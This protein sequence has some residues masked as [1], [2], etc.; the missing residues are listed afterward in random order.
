MSTQATF[1]AL[2]N[3]SQ[4]PLMVGANVPP[5]VMLTIS[6]DQQLY[7]KAYNDY[8]D[9][10][11]DMPG[12]DKAIETSYKH[13]INY[14]GYF[15]SAKCYNY[16]VANRRFDPAA[17]VDPTTRYCSGQWSGNFLNWL[18]MSR[19]DAI[20][21]LLYGGMRSTD[22]VTPAG[23][24]AATAAA[25]VTVLERAYLPSDAH[26]WAKHYSGADLNKLTPFNVPTT[27]TTYA[28]T[29]LAFNIPNLNG[30]YLMTFAAS[31]TAN[32]SVG[33]QV[34]VQRAGNSAQ[35]FIGAVVSITSGNLVTF[36]INTAGVQ[37]SG[38][39]TSWNVTNLSRTGVSFCNMTPG[40]GGAD[41]RSSTNSQP[42]LIRVARGNFALWNASEGIQ[43]QWFEDRNNNQA[44]FP[45]GF[46]SNGNQLALSEI[47]ASAE[48]PSRAAHGLGTGSAVGEYIARVRVCVA[49]MLGDEKCARYP[50]GNFK[51]VG[52]LQEYGDRDLIHFGLMTGSHIK[53]IS[54]GVLR[55]NVGTI[56][57]EIN[58]NTD[59]TFVRPY[60]PAGSPRNTGS[61][62]EPAGI[63]NTL[64][65]MRIYGYDYSSAT[66]IGGNGD[67][68]TYQ[69]TSISENTCTSW[70]NPMSEVY[71]ESVRYFAGGTPTPAY[72]YSGASRDN[73]LG[74]PIVAAA[75]WNPGLA[76]HTYCAS[77]NII[78]FNA[79][80]STNDTDL[81]SAAASQIGGPAATTIGALTNRVGDAEGI[82]NGR[83]FIGKMLGGTPTPA[84]DAGFELCTPKTVTALGDVSG[85]CPEGPTTAGSYLIAGVAHYAKTNRIRS[86]IAVPAGN[87]QALKVSTYGI[88]L[89]TNTPSI[90]I[91]VPGSAGQNIVIQPIYRL[92]LPDGTVGGGSLV[93]MKFVR[94]STVGQISTGKI[95]VNWEDSE[96]GGD[97]DQ[98]MWGTLE[99]TLDAATRT[100]KITTNAISASSANGQGFGYAISGT[101]A[102]TDGPHFHS[103]IYGFNF[104]DPTGVLGCTNCRL[105]TEGV[106]GSQTGEQSV[107]YNGI[108]GI[109]GGALKDPL[110]YAAKYGGFSDRNNNGLP[111][112]IDARGLADT[113]E[114]DVR[115]TDGSAGSDGIPDNYFLVSNPLGLEQALG[116][117][118][119]NILNTSAF[120]SVAA[121]STSLRSLSSI[122]QASFISDDWHGK[123]EKFQID[124]LGNVDR[125]SRWEAGDKL[126]NNPAVPAKRTVITFDDSAGVKDG[127]PFRWGMISAGLTAALNKSPDSGANDGRG[128]DRL[129]WLR[130]D[131][132]LGRDPTTGFRD[133]RF[134]L[135]GDIVNS[136]PVFVGPPN[137][138]ILDPTYVTFRDRKASRAPML[139]VGAN[140]GMLHGFDAVELDEK[141]AYIPSK[142]FPNLARLTSS[143]YSHRFYVDGTPEVADA[144]IGG[145][146]AD[147][148]KTVLVGALGL[149]G[150]GLY[151]LDVTDVNFSEG[152]AKNTVLWEFNDSD[153][154]DLG[155]VTGKPVIRKVMHPT[156]PSKS[157]WAVIVSGGYNN[158][159]GDAAASITGRAY[160]FVIFL[161]GPGPGRVW[162]ENIDYVKIDTGVGSVGTP[163]GLAPPLAIDANRDGLTD[164]VYAGDLQG[165]MWKFDLRDPSFALW[166]DPTRRVKLTQAREGTAALAPVQAITARADAIPHPTGRG[167]IIL[168]GTGK[169]LETADRVAPHGLETFYGIWDKDDRRASG[170]L[171]KDQTTVGSR[172]QLL[173]QTIVNAPGPNGLEARIV[174][175]TGINWS[176]DTTPPTAEDSLGGSS[177]LRHMGWYMDF[178][179]SASTGERVVFRP[180]VLGGRLIFTTLIPSAGLC[181]AGGNSY[182][183]VVNPATGARFDEAVIDISGDGLLNTGDQVAGVFAAGLKTG[184]TPTPTI[185]VGD[186]GTP[187]TRGSKAFIKDDERKLLLKDA[188]GR[189]TWREVLGK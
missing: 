182:L 69:L 149:G 150:Q 85:I 73:E 74:L 31:Q 21:K 109:A 83:Y 174:S 167:Y 102:A 93:D 99:W 162:R 157:K 125:V 38:S 14:Y 87:N 147:H 131:T 26:A 152:D 9:L 141:L 142:T 24:D 41:S 53:N 89:S 106:V 71:F 45:G 115:K 33:D 78:G 184:I 54:G 98:D 170:G 35:F 112:S 65:Y 189:V 86:D 68:C 103:G 181:D 13:S 88:Q 145:N 186:P 2:L 168:F 36:R 56:A 130:G 40:G 124:T 173:E 126:L 46:R 44:G 70:G 49:S 82:T 55:K 135:L 158:S 136:D 64:N 39:D 110:W 105:V 96:Q 151:A 153:D 121:N 79:S 137:S 128:E 19:M 117:A 91:A 25:N 119:L 42:P 156:D 160:L 108:T 57:N 127:V 59:G 116:R 178:P 146:T 122:Y 97:Y 1:G 165:N 27:P 183:M 90:T 172:A 120:T 67:N 169:Y 37:G 43:C 32:M 159:E 12:G 30:D 15:D 188:T 179:S 155:Y 60:R 50:R 111:D 10:D 66:Y 133:R 4:Q 185:V 113:T 23:A 3:L 16:S 47:A 100:L 11:G 92:R 22:Q 58:V 123:L 129:N 154:K 8:S 5:K 139:Y 51:P 166:Q 148:W 29:A 176:T 63:I 75:S 95:Y 17:P 77:L 161:D 164:Y 18:S 94:Q 48:N 61:A 104:T 34:R 84:A 138:V 7:K 144:Q 187:G 171:I 143:S 163:N 118:F 175:K 180:V 177:P 28:A 114:W 62:A 107:T 140:D 52:L 20:R 81:A 76:A 134:G 80:V 6:K 72:D 101:T 132:T